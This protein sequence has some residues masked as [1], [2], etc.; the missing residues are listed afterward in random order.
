MRTKTIYLNNFN[1]I[2]GEKALLIKPLRDTP[3]EQRRAII[4]IHGHGA[5]ASVWTPGW[6][7]ARHAQALADA[8]YYVVSIDAGGP[9]T[10]NNKAAMDA[11]T[12]A[13]GY[14]IGT[15]GIAE[16]KVGLFGWSMG[17]GNS[18]QWI[19]EN[20]SK[21]WACL[22]WAPLTDLDYHLG[23]PP[24]PA[25]GSEAYL[26]YG[27]PIYP[28]NNY[29]LNSTGHKIADEYPTWRNKCPIRIIQGTAD[30]TV[31]MSK[32]Q[33]F[34]N[35]VNAAPGSPAPN[36]VDMVL[37]TGSDHT[38]LFANYP[39]DETLK[40]FR[41]NEQPL[42]IFVPAPTRVWSPESVMYQDAARTTLA[43]ANNDPVGS[44]SELISNAHASQATVA[45]QG[46]LKTNVLNGYRVIQFDKVNDYMEAP[47]TART[48]STWFIVAR[49]MTALDAN[50]RGL[51]GWKTNSSNRIY[52]YAS[53]ATGG[54]GWYANEALTVE[55][56][57]GD[58]T[59]WNIICL[60]HA[61]ANL[62]EVWLGGGSLADSFNPNDNLV[63]GITLM[64]GANNEVAGTFGDFQYAEID[65]YGLAL[66]DDQ[67][68]AVGEALATKYGL[69]W[70]TIQ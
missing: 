35:G 65:R 37:L 42:D 56:I 24:D 40:F 26:A 19:K 54:Y 16:S 21:V 12:S 52:M 13:Y 47:I 59:Q 60:R 50:G 66:S 48:A 69:A 3:I 8:G 27:T 41:D 32:S 25:P 39:L 64:L 43:V 14:I 9:A 44:W 38:T 70:A 22:I 33:A 6:P 30:T 1:G 49:K 45:K 2:T 10:F 17:G 5:D 29:A 51:V 57:G 68:D 36:I 20:P 18:L 34:I 63:T 7:G 62:V 15:L 46:L 31:P 58:P 55:N 67:V 28:T 11:I 53:T 23:Y 61:D 4:A